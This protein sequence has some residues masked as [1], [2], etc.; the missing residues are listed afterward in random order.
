[1]DMNLN[2]NFPTQFIGLNRAEKKKCSFANLDVEKKQ[3][4][5]PAVFAGS[6][7]GLLERGEVLSSGS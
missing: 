1:M 5:A 6:E 3:I 4:S 2:H 7:H